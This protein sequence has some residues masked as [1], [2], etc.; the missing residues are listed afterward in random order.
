M[1]ND[2]SVFI[3]NNRQYQSTFVVKATKEVEDGE[4]NKTKRVFVKFTKV[5]EPLRTDP[6]TGNLLSTGFTEVSK[7]EFS[8]LMKLKVFSKFIEKGS[9][10][11]YDEA[12][13]G[14]LLDSQIVSSLR[15]ENAALKE[16]IKELETLVGVS[17]NGK[18][19]TKKK[20]T[21]KKKTAEVEDT[22]VEE[23]EEEINEENESSEDSETPEF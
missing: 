13:E 21:N 3:K 14:A 23:E 22:P 11:C 12:P 2:V 1:K 8:D 16:R 6:V 17:L 7:E 19:N 20:G 10:V 9:F 5:F 4:G 15:S 18:E